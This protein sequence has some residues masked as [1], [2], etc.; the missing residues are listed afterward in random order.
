[1]CSLIS[2]PFD[3]NVM[4]HRL[5]VNGNAMLPRQI[6]QILQIPHGTYCYRLSPLFN[7]VRHVPVDSNTRKAGIP[8]GRRPI[9]Y[10]SNAHRWSKRI[11][12]QQVQMTSVSG[13]LP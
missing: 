2:S 3:D 9:T 11:H 10:T 8:K 13:F 12:S 6:L 5:S 7:D 4:V 1:M